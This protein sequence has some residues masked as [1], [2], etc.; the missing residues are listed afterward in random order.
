M[1]YCIVILCLL[2][3]CLISCW[4]TEGYQVTEGYMD[5]RPPSDRP[6]DIQFY[7]CHDYSNSDNLGNTNYKLH[8]HDI[9]PP[10]QGTYSH[11]LNT[12]KLRNYDELFHSPICQGEYNFETVSG[13]GF[14]EIVD[15]LDEDREDLLTNERLL[16]LYN[17]K[18]PHYVYVNPEYIGNTL[19]YPENINE[20]FLKNHRSHDAEN[21]SHRLDREITI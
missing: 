2:V 3:I 10:L 8:T 4:A 5:N 21:L 1:N 9:Q 7:A 14:R 20:L 18:D 12:Y 15:S 17:I 11:F 6:D 16:D 19:I 13:L